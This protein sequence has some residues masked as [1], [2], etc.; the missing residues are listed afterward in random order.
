M[1]QIVDVVDSA[2]DNYNLAYWVEDDTVALAELVL[3]LA[4]RQGGP[5][6]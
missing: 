3:E 2:E 1:Q 5:M 4:R 6:W